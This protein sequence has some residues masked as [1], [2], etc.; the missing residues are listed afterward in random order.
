MRDGHHSFYRAVMYAPDMP[1]LLL[2]WSLISQAA[3]RYPIIYP[4]TNG[5][6][7]KKEQRRSLSNSIIRRYDILPP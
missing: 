2:T 4:E 1:T 7:T 3:D 6:D 5:R